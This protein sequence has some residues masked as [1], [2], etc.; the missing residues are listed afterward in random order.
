MPQK[1]YIDNNSAKKYILVLFVLFIT[2][3]IHAQDLQ[4]FID[5]DYEIMYCSSNNGEPQEIQEVRLTIKG[6]EGK[7]W[8][9]SYSVNDSPAIIANGDKGIDI[10]EY[11]LKLLLKNISTKAQQYTIVLKEAW[12]EGDD[13]DDDDDDNIKELN[14]P[15]D[16]NSASIQIL[17]LAQPEVEDYFPKAKT[18]STQNYNASI[19]KNSSY[20]V[21]VPKNAKLIE[22]KSKIDGKK[23]V[24]D[25]KIEWSGKE[26]NQLF[27]L[28]ETDAYGC[29]SDTI[30]AGVEL[31][32]SFSVDLGKDKTI[33]QG[34]DVTLSP[35]IDLPATYSYVWNNGETSKEITV[36]ESGNYKLTVKDLADNQTVEASVNVKVEAKPIIPLN[37]LVVLESEESDVDIS[38]AGCTYLWSD[39]Y[40][41][42]V[43]T[44]EKSG[45]YTVQKTSAT[46]CTTSKSFRVK[47]E[48]DLYQIELPKLIHMCG[49]EKMT[50]SP[51]VN[52]DQE[53]EYQW[54]TGS[55]E[56]SIPIAEEGTYSVTVSDKD[57]F[58]QSASTEVVYHPNPIVYLGPDQILWEGEEIILDAENNGSSFTWNT[59]ET[60]QKIA[61]TSGGLFVV[62]VSD[63]YGCSNKDT[64]YIEHKQGH[65]FGVYM[66]E[67][68]SICEGDS[69]LVQVSIEGNP[70]HP[71]KY[72]WPISGKTTPEVYLKTGGIHTINVTDANGNMET[73]SININV[74]ETPKVDLGNDLVSYPNQHIILDAGTPNC[75][76]TW[77]TGE[78][79]QKISVKTEGKYFV[80]VTNESNCSNTDTIMVGFLED[81]PFVGL[82]KAF[83]PNGDGHNDKLFIRGTNIK[84]ISLI[85]YNRLGQKIFSTNNVNTGWDGFFKGEIQDIDV[86]VYV[87]EVTYLDGKKM[88]K[89]GNVALLR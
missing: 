81:Y 85:L 75:L 70:T 26:E 61:V 49:N 42:G 78:I 84:E 80:K 45:A 10:S 77:S 35:E 65:R 8:F 89:K 74:L 63:I 57:G 43:R 29:N 36:N 18:N 71:L 86:Y 21:L 15:K 11:D 24:V 20:E 16:K 44:F 87:I 38:S 51:S 53:L 17:P 37:D 52:T 60:T 88:T 73:A 48:K 14:I 79:T 62:E 58:S 31:V 40:T 12:I 46:G 7:K 28:I 69:V 5:Q 68:K 34:E 33:C 25:V 76:Y 9:V 4:V 54:S 59:G 1:P 32:H 13:D 39:G 67:D 56:K 41:N 82:P 6:P 47:L 66:G 2:T 64:I 50:L 23:Q 3:A 55:T 30:Y 22:S 72:H 83:S 27:K 19:G